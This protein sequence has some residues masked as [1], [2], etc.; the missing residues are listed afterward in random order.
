MRGNNKSKSIVH[1]FMGSIRIRSW[2]REWAE[3]A[4]KISAISKMQTFEVWKQS[5]SL[6]RWTR[7]VGYVVTCGDSRKR[8]PV[9]T[10]KSRSFPFVI[11]IWTIIL[12]HHLLAV[13]KRNCQQTTNDDSSLC[14]STT[15]IFPRIAPSACID[16]YR[17]QGQYFI[18]EE[19]FLS[20]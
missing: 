5:L 14:T 8:G 10:Y 13:Y 6:P 1:L 16:R 17:C 12:Q 20:T 19:Q 7:R 2:P 4:H 15:I 18:H 11:P 3:D 9:P